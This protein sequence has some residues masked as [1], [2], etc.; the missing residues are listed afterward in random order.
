[1]ISVNEILF[2][3]ADSEDLI[4]FSIGAFA[5]FAF[6]GALPGFCLFFGE[7]IDS[8]ADTTQGGGFGS[9]KDTSLYML[10][11]SFFVWVSSAI[12]VSFMALFAERIA[13]KVKNHYFEKC[14]EKDA[15]WYD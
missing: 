15:D 13:F 2:K 14:L 6:G 7:M 5:S 12:Q 8:M 9:L 4:Y 10:Y 11:F 3:F 1:M